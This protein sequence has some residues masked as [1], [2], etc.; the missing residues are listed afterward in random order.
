MKVNEFPIVKEHA[1]LACFKC[2][3]KRGNVL[4]SGYPKGRG[5]WLKFCLKCGKRTFYDISE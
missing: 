2:G 5:A 3:S 4:K 1:E